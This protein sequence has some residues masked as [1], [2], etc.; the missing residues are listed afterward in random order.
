MASQA[1]ENQTTASEARSLL[2]AAIEEN[3]VP[4]LAQALDLFRT[5]NPKRYQKVVKDTFNT[6][7]MRGHTPLIAH[8]LDHEDVSVSD[9]R[10]AFLAEHPSI[11][12]FEVLVSHGWDVNSTNA[13]DGEDEEN[14]PRVI[15][16]VI[17]DYDKVKWLIDHGATVTHGVDYP[18]PSHFMGPQVPLLEKCTYMGSVETLKLLKEHG[19]R[20]GRHPLHK[21]AE[22]AAADGADPAAVDES[23]QSGKK[24]ERAAMLRYLVDELGLDVNQMDEPAP[25][26]FLSH[27]GTPIH[28][29]ARWPT[30]AA[31]VKWLLEKG[32]DPTIKNT[33]DPGMPWD[34]EHWAKVKGCDEVLKVIQE[35]KKAKMGKTD[36]A[37]V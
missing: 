21:A 2:D 35:W 20:F 14:C 26:S 13:R 8:M 24:A 15:N 9:A 31:V 22:Q 12:L 32:A 25:Y 6:A 33:A 17:G 36:D 37:A 34:A 18:N 27:Y 29:A 10:L 1:P 11:E 19:A 23:A 28:Y 5:K 7:L 4:K 30:G 3:S 16:L